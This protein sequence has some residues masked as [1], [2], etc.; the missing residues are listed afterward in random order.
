MFI[1]ITD[2]NRRIWIRYHFVTLGLVAACVLGFMIQISAGPGWF[3]KMVFGFGMIPSVLFGDARLPPE[4]VQ[5]PPILTLFTYIFLHGGLLHLGGNMLFLWVFG[6]N[7]EDSMGHKRFLV[8]FLLTGAAAALVQAL[9]A[10]GSEAPIVGASGAVS[11]VLGAYL[12]LH[13]RVQVWVLM[14]A[15]I[16][17]RLPTWAVLGGWIAMQVA[18]ALFGGDHTSNVAWFAHVGGFFAGA[19]LI[20][21][22]KMPH[23]VLWDTSAF[24]GS[25]LGGLEL[26]RRGPWGRTGN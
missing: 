15:W 18:Y 16:P 25:G 14:F 10:P 17:L 3:N 19:V 20:R 5:A 26:R 9:M 6:D 24:D 4:I 12:V 21:W 1:P 23:V 7:V 8:F 11:G 22:F 13:P 2:R